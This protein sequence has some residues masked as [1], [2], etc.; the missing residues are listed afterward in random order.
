MTI[1]EREAQQLGEPYEVR[2][3]SSISTS[4]AEIKVEEEE[5]EEAFMSSSMIVKGPMQS[6]MMLSREFLRLGG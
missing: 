3:A 5:G 2:C 4:Y 1:K 6:L